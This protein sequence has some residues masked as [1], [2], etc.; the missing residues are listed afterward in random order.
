MSDYGEQ[1]IHSDGWEDDWQSHV[2]DMG[3]RLSGM[4]FRERYVVPSR[5]RLWLGIQG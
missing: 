3:P 5:S 1:G 4:F 2:G